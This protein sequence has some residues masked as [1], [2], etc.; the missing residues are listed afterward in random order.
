MQVLL[1][2]TLTPHGGLRIRVVKE[3][4]NREVNGLR[5]IGV[6]Q[7]PQQR[8]QV[9]NPR[10][11]RITRTVE[12]H[13]RHTVQRATRQMTGNLSHRRTPRHPQ[14]RS[15]INQRIKQRRG[16]AGHLTHT[17]DGGRIRA[18]VYEGDAHLIAFADAALQ[19]ATGTEG[20]IQ[21]DLHHAAF[22]STFE[23][24][25]HGGAR[26]PQTSRDSVHRHVVDVVQL[27]RLIGMVSAF[28]HCS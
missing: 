1:N 26:N 5:I 2:A 21:A 22:T 15:V 14:A 28:V 13:D 17:R 24:T 23:Q 7:L 3:R 19:F 25:R 27:R 12:L 9:R 18:H 11:V 10:M 8:T 4:G 16:S 6:H 20:F